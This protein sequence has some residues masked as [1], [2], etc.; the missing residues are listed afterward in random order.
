MTATLVAAD[1]VVVVVI[2]LSANGALGR[3]WSGGLV[4]GGGLGRAVAVLALDR[5]LRGAIT[6]LVLD[7]GSLGGAITVLGLDWS[8]GRAV[9]VLSLN[10]SLRGSVAVLLC[11]SLW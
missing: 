3:G 10:G 8:L 9:T 4:H 5:S 2:A 6:V 7:R 1:W 11:G